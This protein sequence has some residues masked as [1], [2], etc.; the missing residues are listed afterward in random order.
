MGAD[1]DEV[2]ASGCVVVAAEADGFAIK[3][4]VLDT[5]LVYVANIGGAIV[6]R[7]IQQRFVRAKGRVGE[8]AEGEACPLRGRALPLRSKLNVARGW[9]GRWQ[10]YWD[11]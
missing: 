9:D 11:L 2:D 10:G 6:A 5:C 8:L 1:G 3:P 4:H 7:M